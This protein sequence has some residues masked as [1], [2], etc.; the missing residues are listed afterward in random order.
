MFSLLYESDFRDGRE[1]VEHLDDFMLG[2]ILAAITPD[3]RLQAAA[4]EV[5]EHP[6]ADAAQIEYRREIVRDF[7]ARKLPIDRLSELFGGFSNIQN[8]Y[9]NEKS[10]LFR[11]FGG[12]TD[13]SELLKNA[14]G[15]VQELI[16]LINGIYDIFRGKA[17]ISKGLSALKARITELS[18][19][20]DMRKLYNLALNFRNF[21][22]A[23]NIT[24]TEL[25]IGQSGKISGIGMISTKIMQRVQK[26]NFGKKSNPV[27]VRAALFH[28][29]SGEII[30]ASAKELCET[31]ELVISM[32]CGEFLQVN[33][34]LSFYSFAVKYCDTLKKTGVPAVY[35]N[36]DDD[37][38]VRELYDLYLLLTLPSTET[39]VQNDFKLPNDVEGIIITGKNSSGKTVFLRAA[40]LALIFTTAGLPIAA[41]AAKIALPQAILLQMASSERAYHDGDITGRF[42][43]EV[44]DMKQ[45]VDE[46]ASGTLV[47]LNE[48][49][50]TTDYTE[51]AEGLFYILRHLNRKGAKWVLVTHLKR[52]DEMF[53]K[54]D[55]IFKMSTDCR[56]KYKLNYRDL[57]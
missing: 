21:S 40:T 16:E 28:E 12:R 24:E 29:E 49:F 31:F 36:F 38:D 25:V 9:R 34:D 14:A 50:Q 32:I 47:V 51:G 23:E 6:L 52:I 8:D 39:V 10:R 30:S 42:E 20:L 43:E 41:K 1:P 35:A 4:R 11:L 33:Y 15:A 2:K 54:A 46:A 19:S 7:A 26:H 37:T 18:G 17:P 53:G 3:I 22:S 56:E 57:L 27:G 48:V 13:Y 5:L 45:I 44:I 55:N